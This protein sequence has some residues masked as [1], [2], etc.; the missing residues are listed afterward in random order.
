MYQDPNYKVEDRTDGNQITYFA[1]F[2]M[3]IG[4]SLEVMDVCKLRVRLHYPIFFGGVTTWD[5]KILSEVSLRSNNLTTEFSSARVNYT[6]F[7]ELPTTELEPEY[8]IDTRGL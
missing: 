4:Y 6:I 3:K 7:V 1:D 2:R 8:I 5:D